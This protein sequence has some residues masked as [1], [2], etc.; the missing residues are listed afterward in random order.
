MLNRFSM[1]STIVRVEAR[2][3]LEPLVATLGV[4]PP[5]WGATFAARFHRAIEAHTVKYELD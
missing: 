5:C 3:G 1:S 2:K 4:T